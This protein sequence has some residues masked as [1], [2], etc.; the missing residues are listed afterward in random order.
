MSVLSLSENDYEILTIKAS[1]P[2]GQ[3][4]NKVETA[5]QLRFD[6][7]TSSL[8]YEDRNIFAEDVRNEVVKLVKD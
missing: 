7:K 1:G 8:N 4:V 3:R 6:I 2:G 5:I